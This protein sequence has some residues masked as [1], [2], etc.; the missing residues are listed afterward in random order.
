MCVPTF[1][2][3]KTAMHMKEQ[4]PPSFRE[5]WIIHKGPRGPSTAWHRL[6]NSFAHVRLKEKCGSNVSPAIIFFTQKNRFRSLGVSTRLWTGRELLCRVGYVHLSV[7]A[8][9]PLQGLGP[10]EWFLHLLPGS[11]QVRTSCWKNQVNAVGV[12]SHQEAEEENPSQ[13]PPRMEQDHE[14]V[15]SWGSGSAPKTK[16]RWWCFQVRTE[17]VES[18]QWR[19]QWN[20]RTSWGAAGISWFFFLA[21]P[22]LPCAM[23]TSYNF[24]L[25]CMCLLPRPVPPPSPT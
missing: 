19:R 7:K 14:L 20:C 24:Y 12:A 25:E 8:A 17:C 1:W 4:M 22:M 23:Y 15:H 6:V 11:P 18:C 2:L 16:I 10:S 5:F 21:K 3:P 9:S 13:R